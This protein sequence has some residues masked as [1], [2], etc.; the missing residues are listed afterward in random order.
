MAAVITSELAPIAVLGRIHGRFERF[1]TFLN[2]R[3]PPMVAESA[4]PARGPLS[5]AAS[6]AGSGRNGLAPPKAECVGVAERNGS[7]G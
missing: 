1:A 4:S 3:F 2:G 6:L 5:K 7:F